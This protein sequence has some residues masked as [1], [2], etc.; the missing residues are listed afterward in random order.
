MEIKN[1]DFTHYLRKTLEMMDDPGLL[2]L[3]GNANESNVMTIGWGTIGIIWGKPIFC[4]LVRPSRYTDN[5][6]KKYNEFTVNV[7]SAGM[8]KTVLYCGT[9]SG[10]NYNKFKKKNIT[11]LPGKKVKCP[12][13][14]KCD[15]VYE[16]RVIHKN[17]IVPAELM[18]E[19]SPKYYPKGDY[20]T[21]YFGEILAVYKQS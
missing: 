3:S 21:I 14:K 10:K 4:V 20:H 19:I 9:V 7:P 8:E 12:T 6:I 15:I 18:F 1:L 2:L 5:F 13:I 11:L 17:S 16:C